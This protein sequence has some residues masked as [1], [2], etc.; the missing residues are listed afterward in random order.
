MKKKIK[1]KRNEV[2]YLLKKQ[3]IRKVEDLDA[4]KLDICH[5]NAAGVDMGSRE[6]YLA[7]PPRI[8]KKLNLPI[9]HRFSTMTCGLILALELLKKCDIDT[10][11]ME[12]TS[13]YWMPFFDILTENKIK[14]C[15]VNPKKF[16][17]VPGRKTDILDSQWLQI[18]H[19]YGLLRGSFHPDENTDMLRSL[20]RTRNKVVK[21]SV[22]YVQRMQKAFT[23]MNILLTNVLSNIVGESGIR[24][25]EAIIAGERSPDKLYSFCN[26]NIKAT[27]KEFINALEGHYREDHLFLVKF[28]Y[29]SWRFNKK[30]IEKLD[31]K[32]EKFLNKFPLK[33]KRSEKRPKLKNK[34]QSRKTKNQVKTKEYLEDILFRIIGIDTATLPGIRGHFTL[35]V[36][37]EVG[38]DMNKFPNADH[39][40]SYMGFV[41]RNK[42]TGGRII[43][44]R[45]DRIKS[46]AAQAFR[47]VIPSISRSDT[48]LGAFYRRLAPRIGKAA[49]TVATARKLSILFYNLLVHGKE[50]IEHGAAKYLEQQKK[51]KEKQFRKLAKEL[52]YNI[53]KKEIAVAQ[54]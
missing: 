24:I 18:L 19:A 30:Q 4:Y 12:S 41:P 34:Q 28:N 14:V 25:I 15:L 49:A 27:E 48:A 26:L 53:Q 8:A 36:I 52:S 45:T 33:K 43:S 1:N 42:I 31:K 51:R 3:K 54:A 37:S 21:E 50:Y 23:R 7:L 46:S 38:T 10:V 11:S 39:F 5:P 22:R 9:V 44:S 20:M 13:V 35:K 6:F 29:E 17:M 16:R 32:I 40:A 47:E 2:E